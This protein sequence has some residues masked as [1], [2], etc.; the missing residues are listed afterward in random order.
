MSEGVEPSA[1]D[2]LA[3]RLGVDKAKGGL[4]ALEFLF[5][6]LLVTLRRKALI[7]DAEIEILLDAV[8]NKLSE[9][10][11][12]ITGAN[13]EAAGYIDRMKAGGDRIFNLIRS[14]ISETDA[15]NLKPSH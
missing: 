11:D 9:S 8:S 2:I 14:E 4:L 10:Y 3:S 13:P 1:G 6:G 7:E 12:S 15:E 5:T